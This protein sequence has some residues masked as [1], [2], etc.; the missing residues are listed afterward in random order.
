LTEAELYQYKAIK[1]EIKDI[2]KRIKETK[3]EAEVIEFGTVKGSSKF[4]PYTP[5]NFH[6][7]G[8]DPS[9]AAS[10]QKT[11]SELLRQREFKKNELI[12]K[13]L[14]IEE[15]ISGINDS[16]TRLIFR[17]HFLDGD[18]Q[19]KVAMTTHYTQGRVSQIIK[20]Y[21]KTN[22]INKQMC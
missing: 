4:F 11:I 21:I 2:N 13:Q 15:Y 18:S 19:I 7:S 3:Q 9:D 16:T 1:E 5:Q 10:R 22:K 8:I 17:L 20:N 14:E 12:K 6:V